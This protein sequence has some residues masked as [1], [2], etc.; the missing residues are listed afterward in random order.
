[1][2]KSVTAIIFLA[3]VAGCSMDGRNAGKNIELIEKYVQAVENLDYDA[4][5]TYLDDQYIGMGP[6]YGDTIRKTQ[7][8][9]NWKL[10]VDNLYESIKYNRSRNIAVSITDGDNQGEWVSNWAEL[11]IV[12]KEGRGEVTILA[13]TIYKVEDGKIIQSLTFYNEADAMR[14][15]G[16]VCLDLNDL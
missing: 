3:L 16:F 13:N 11:D 8:I 4:M 10:H 12:Y 15:L 2:F 6:S 5:G 14:Q 1:M 7:A 9:E